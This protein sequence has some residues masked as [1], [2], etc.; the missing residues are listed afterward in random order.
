MLNL[1][2]EKAEEPVKAYLNREYDAHLPGN[3]RLHPVSPDVTCI[4]DG[5]DADLD[6]FNATIIQ[7]P[8]GFGKTY[9]IL[10]EILPRV[11]QSGG[12]MLLVSNRV[13][14]SYQQ[15]LEVMEMV[16]PTEISCLTPE[17]VLKKTD[18]GPVKVMTLQ[19]VDRFLSTT[20]GRE[21]AKEVS[22][23]VVDEVHYFVADVSFNPSAA[24][25]LKVIPQFFN[26]ATRIYMTATLEDVLRPL[27]EEAKAK[28]PLAERTGVRFSPLVY[29]QTP[30][31]D[32]YAYKSDKYSS[33]PIR[34][35]HR[36]ND[37]YREIKE[38][39]EDKWLIFVPSK[40]QGAILQETLG[41]DAVFIS[42]GSK[43]SDMWNQLLDEERLPC[44]VLI[45][46]SVLDCGVNI[47]DEDLRHVVI[48]FEDRTM[49]M[50]ALGRVRF[51]GTP[52]FTLYVKSLTKK[53]HNGLVYRNRELLSLAAEIKQSK[54]YSYYVDRFRLEGDRAKGAL[55]YL[56]YDGRYKFNN[57]LYHKLLRQE[58]YYKK[59]AEA[60]DKYGDS[61]FPRIVH[62][63]LGQPDAYDEQNWIGYDTANQT[64]QDLLAFLRKHDG[65][66]LATENDQRAFS[67]K[68]HQC[69]QIITGGK[70][71][72]NRGEGY[73]KT[74][75]LNDCLKK[76]GINGTVKSNGKSG[77]IFSMVEDK[78]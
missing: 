20:Q 59:L 49:F 9:F 75:A 12:K 37:L 71:R 28:R 13:A 14:V 19:A 73:I 57:L 47:Y 30:V 8:T 55:L 66:L 17:G 7:A 54:C 5:I 35:F 6:S 76:V 62:D 74:A 15:K 72:D 50:Q 45:T 10:H 2:K 61:A 64:R 41:D 38:S 29:G 48:P 11:M 34:Y 32:L 51:K 53:S 69:Y 42:A 24:R 44:R 25:L 26:E 67:E 21:Y 23:L 27:A 46:T 68:V 58:Q 78:K 39:G 63:W 36:E 1:K 3:V 33:L 22:V 52:K 31:I 56:D 4:A 16:D 18:F 40:E 65:K 60:I 43:G 70:K 77:W